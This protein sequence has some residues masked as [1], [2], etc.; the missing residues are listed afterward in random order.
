MATCV[1]E[2]GYNLSHQA[3]DVLMKRYQRKINGRWLV[4][5]DDF[6]AAAVRVRAL[7][8]AFRKHDAQGNGW[9]QMHFDTFLTTALYY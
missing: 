5:F 1:R 9:A 2:F 3:Y 8:E 6:L 4:A 7:S